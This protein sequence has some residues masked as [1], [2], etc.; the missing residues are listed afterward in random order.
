MRQVYAAATARWQRVHPRQA[1]ALVGGVSAPWW[2]AGGWALDLF[3]GE[4]TRPHQDL[5][6]GILR[7]DV[8][9]ILGALSGW[10]FFEARD[11]ELSG[12]LAGEPLRDVN[13][14]WGRMS[15]TDEWLLELMLDDAEGAEWVFRRDRGVRR[16]LALA[17]RHDEERIPYLAPEVQLL[18]KASHIRP[19]DEADFLRV[20][21]HLTQESCEWLRG[22]LTRLNPRHPWLPALA[23]P[24]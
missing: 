7:R 18:Y 19:R 10:E 11:G 6:L 12:P 13:S 20:T 21:P 4:Q 17:I 15:G 24:A 23:G 8:H 3:L 2:I 9:D 22:A 14:L 1:A 16:A 5:D